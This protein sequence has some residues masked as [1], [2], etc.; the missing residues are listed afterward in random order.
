[1]KAMVI[2]QGKVHEIG[3]NKKGQL[4]FYNHTKA[5]LKAEGALEKLGGTPCKCYMILQNWRNGG[6]LPTELSVEYDKAE[7]KR[8][9]RYI[10]RRKQEN[11]KV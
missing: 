5:E 11:A 8:I 4:I 10:K 3:L 6:P 9:Q 1:M 2:C 7:A